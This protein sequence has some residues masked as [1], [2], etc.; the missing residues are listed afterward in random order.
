MYSYEWNSN[1]FTEVFWLHISFFSAFLCKCL[2]TPFMYLP[3]VFYNW[4]PS[5]WETNKYIKI[6]WT[7]CYMKSNEFC[8]KQDTSIDFL[9]AK[10]SVLGLHL[11]ML[12]YNS[13]FCSH[14]GFNLPVGSAQLTE[15][16]LRTIFLDYP[17]V[18][19]SGYYIFLLNHSYRSLLSF[20]LSE[21]QVRL[22]IWL[23]FLDV[24]SQ[25]SG[26]WNNYLGRN[27]HF[28]SIS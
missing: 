2:P 4:H 7:T 20:F 15:F 24:I 14:F 26:T 28:S 13:H 16:F 11:G 25:D 21:V 3:L 27:D 12:I 5:F 17:S 18:I 6:N 10:F 22:P 9:L 1:F 19:V 23:I 8:I